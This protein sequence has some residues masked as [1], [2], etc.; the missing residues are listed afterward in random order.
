M[1][2]GARYL[3]KKRW[4]KA[5]A[6]YRKVIMLNPDYAGAHFKLGATLGQVCVYSSVNLLP[7]HCGPHAPWKV[8][9]C[10]QESLAAVPGGYVSSKL[11]RY[12]SRKTVCL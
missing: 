2:R 8:D 6:E 7:R 12:C 5:E 9:C 1:R 11:S 10:P 3:V 4:A